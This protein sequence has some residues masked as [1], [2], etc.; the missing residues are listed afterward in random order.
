MS[1]LLNPKIALIFLTLIPQFI[2][3]GEEPFATTAVLA[4]AFLVMG[5]VW[6]RIFWL[7]VGVLGSIMA[8]DRVRVA[9]ERVT[10]LVLITLGV[11]VAVAHH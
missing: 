5:I 8:R 10:G 3:R 4:A 6:W 9:V 7:A 1:N 2:S 11:R